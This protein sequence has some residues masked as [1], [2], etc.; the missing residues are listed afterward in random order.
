MSVIS[1]QLLLLNVIMCESDK[2]VKILTVLLGIC[3][4]KTT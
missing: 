2:K 4:Q 3:E 1:T